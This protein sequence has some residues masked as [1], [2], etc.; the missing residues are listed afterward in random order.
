MEFGGKYI[1]E[2]SRQKVW[3]A[4]N[5]EE[6]LQKTIP[7]CN[8][9]AWVSHDELEL[10]FGVNLG[11]AK[12]VFKGDLIL[13]NVHPAIKYTLSG[14]GRGGILGHAQG[15]ADISLS[16]HEAGTLLIFHAIGGGSGRIMSLGEKVIGS[17]A[18]KIIDRF[19]ARFAEAM[20]VNI[21]VLENDD[22]V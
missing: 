21:I 9:I 15:E 1:I 12:P 11:I 6:V 5:D 3:R 16:D 18:Q 19:F 10:E 8:K 2:T 4:L 22:R 20:N 14:S 7:G 17:S 13:S